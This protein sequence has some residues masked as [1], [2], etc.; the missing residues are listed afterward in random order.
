MEVHAYEHGK[1]VITLNSANEDSMIKDFRQ[2]TNTSN[3]LAVYLVFTG[4]E[5]D[6]QASQNE[7]MPSWLNEEINA[8]EI[9]CLGNLGIKI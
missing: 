8:G 3:V 2:M 7:A 4:F 9:K 5:N 6:L 1:F